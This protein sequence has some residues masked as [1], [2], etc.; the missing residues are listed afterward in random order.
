MLKLSLRGLRVVV[1]S[2]RQ[3]LLRG[4]IRVLRLCRVQKSLGSR[5]GLDF[6]R[7][8]GFNHARHWLSVPISRICLFYGLLFHFIGRNY[9]FYC[10]LIVN[11]AVLWTLFEIFIS[12]WHLNRWLVESFSFSMISIY[13][14][15]H[16]KVVSAFQ[17]GHP[18]S[19]ASFD[20]ESSLVVRTTLRI[21][22]DIE[23]SKTPFKI[24]F[25]KL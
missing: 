18:E 5:N 7:G 22:H 20:L 23:Q 6:L 8:R 9:S 12:A 16:V 21:L 1:S 3:T 14:P 25:L 15:L 4:W 24:L 11:S 2:P 17:S 19:P 13:C 10:Y